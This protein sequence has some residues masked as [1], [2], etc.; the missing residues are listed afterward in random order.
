[1]QSLA[2]GLAKLNPSAA[3]LALFNVDFFGRVHPAFPPHDARH[4]PMHVIALAMHEE[5][6]AASP[7]HDD[8]PDAVVAPAPK[9]AHATETAATLR[10]LEGKIADLEAE[11]RVLRKQ[12]GE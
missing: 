12:N 8:T 3:S 7:Y 2:A 10:R 1:V 6:G 11:I 9:Q 4:Q 5:L